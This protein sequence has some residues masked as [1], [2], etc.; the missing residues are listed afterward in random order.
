[1][2]FVFMMKR[3]ILFSLI[4]LGAL[5]FGGASRMMAAKEIVYSRGD[6]VIAFG[7][8][9]TKAETYDVSQH[10]VDPALVGMKIK[11]RLGEAF[12]IY[13]IL[14]TLI[15]IL[16]I[17]VGLLFDA[18]RRFGYEAFLSPLIYAALGVIP[19]LFINTDRELS[20]KKLLIRHVI[21]LLII[22]AVMMTV[23]FTSKNIPSEK[24]GMVV[25]LAA[26]IAVIY[27]LSIV[28]EYIFELTQSREMNIAL[29]AYQN[30]RR[31]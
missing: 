20:M 28:V 8:N 4:I 5:L 30:R 10:I 29:E 12:R 27:V 31:N 21:Q 19:T 11:A 6:S 25:V 18:D 24:T 14:V 1:M 17:I 23:I 3:N 2:M 15:T 9:S 16:L 7:T 13:F 22:E 26:G